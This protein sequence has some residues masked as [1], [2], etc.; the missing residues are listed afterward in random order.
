MT[1]TPTPHH[2]FPQVDAWIE[3]EGFHQNIHINISRSKSL[4][5]CHKFLVLQV[6]TQDMFADLDQLQVRP[7]ATLVY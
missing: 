6:V 5:K 3:T 1:M 4:E 2:D 7:R